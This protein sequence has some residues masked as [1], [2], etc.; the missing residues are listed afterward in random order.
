MRSGT[1][2]LSHPRYN[3][4]SKS[5]AQKHN[6]AN[7]IETLITSIPKNMAHNYNI[8]PGDITNIQI[9][10]QPQSY[11]SISLSEKQFQLGSGTNYLHV[12]H[13]P[14]TS[15]Q[16]LLTKSDSQITRCPTSGCNFDATC[17]SAYNIQRIS[18]LFMAY[19][20]DAVSSSGYKASNGRMIKE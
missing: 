17:R 4:A 8:I 18:Y 3:S 14:E 12:L 16:N 10:Q 9:Q 13:A 6:Y 5:S 2:G 15:W 1:V 7:R 19:S 11:S 20:H